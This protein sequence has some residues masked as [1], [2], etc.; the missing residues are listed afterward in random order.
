MPNTV[1]YDGVNGLL[2]SKNDAKISYH[3]RLGC[4]IPIQGN[5]SSPAHSGSAA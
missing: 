1:Y 5:I 3:A 4:V 2:S